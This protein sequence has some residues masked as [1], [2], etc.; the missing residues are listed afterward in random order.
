[1]TPEG[2]IKRSI[3]EYLGRRQDVLFWIQ[4]SQGTYDTKIQRFRKKNSKY[5]LN[6]IADITVL[7]KYGNMPAFYVGLEVKS[8]Q[9]KQTDSQKNFEKLI[10]SI[11]SF[12]YVVRSIEETR[13]ALI[14]VVSRIKR[15]TGVIM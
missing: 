4:E 1:M 7:I 2:A 12:Y 13:L 8:P 3:C 5:Q 10:K 9:G 11:N 6:G 15:L 14:D